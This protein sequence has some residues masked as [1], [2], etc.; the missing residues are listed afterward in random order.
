MLLYVQIVPHQWTWNVGR[1][2][3]S[4]A[5]LWLLLL[6]FTIQNFVWKAYHYP[7][8][9]QTHDS[10]DE[11]RLVRRKAFCQRDATAVKAKATHRFLLILK[12]IIII[13]III[14]IC[15]KDIVIIINIIFE[16]VRTLSL[17]YYEYEYDPFAYVLACLLLVMIIIIIIIIIIMIIYVDS[18]MV[19]AR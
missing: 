15:H 17:L 11:G 19:C 9:R 8:T 7:L 2:I 10:Q 18:H 3:R 13:I 5:A 16:C 4:V 1:N 14:I 12:S 6:F